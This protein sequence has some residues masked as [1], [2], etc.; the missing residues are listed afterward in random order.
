MK[1]LLIVIAVSAIHF[2]NLTSYKL[3]AGKYTETKKMVLIK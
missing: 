2:L 1:K 3:I